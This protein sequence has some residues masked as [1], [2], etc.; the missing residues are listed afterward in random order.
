MRGKLRTPLKFLISTLMMTLIVVMGAT[1]Y[2][3]AQTVTVKPS[4]SGPIWFDDGT[5]GNW[6]CREKGKPGVF[7]NEAGEVVDVAEYKLL[8]D[9]LEIEPMTGYAFYEIGQDGTTSSDATKSDMQKIIW[10]SKYISEYFGHGTPTV[11]EPTSSSTGWEETSSLLPDGDINDNG[12]PDNKEPD[13]NPE[14]YARQHTE[15][16]SDFYVRA[17]DFGRVHYGI[18]K[19]LKD[20]KQI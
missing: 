4:P 10:S 8:E 15:T 13:F 16:A 2:A 14:E 7:K 1:V 19:R 9:N 12:I 17:Q 18:F 3:A 20:Q 6:Y 5:I 11:V